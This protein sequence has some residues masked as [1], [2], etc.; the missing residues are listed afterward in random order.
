VVARLVTDAR[1]PTAWPTW[2]GRRAIGGAATKFAVTAFS[3]ALRQ[4][5]TQ[6]RVRVSA[7]EPGAVSAELT[8][9]IRDSVREHSQHWYA[10]METLQSEDVADAIAYLVT[11]PRHVALNEIVIA[12]SLSWKNAPSAAR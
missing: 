2:S 9:H 4:E 8:H 1:L 7:V 3:E 11:R 10:S 12:P 5:L 6:Q